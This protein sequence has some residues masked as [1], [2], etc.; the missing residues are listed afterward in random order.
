MNNMRVISFFLIGFILLFVSCDK[1]KQT[2]KN[3]EGEWEIISYKLTD[4][5]GMSEYATV[6]GSL[7]FDY[8]T[9]VAVP[10]SYSINITHVF[11]SSTG[12][13]INNGTYQVIEKGDF[14]DVTTLDQNNVIT[15]TY[16]YRIL[17]QTRTDLQLEY[18]D[19]LS[20][21]H[22]FIFQKKK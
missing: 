7:I 11:P 21:I 5:E 9:D 13:T 18:G 17:T 20:R 16:K 15:S 3:L 2:A 19:S 12:S 14:M 1:Q 10:C 22:S 6:Q 4:I 8:C